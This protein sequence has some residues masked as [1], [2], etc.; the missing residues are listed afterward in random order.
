M[1]V[2][3]IR[4]NS[5]PGIVF[6]SGVRRF[7]ALLQNHRM[8]NVGM[9]LWRSSCPALVLKQRYSEPAGFWRSPRRRLHNYSRQDIPVLHYLHITEVL[10]DVQRELL[11]FQFMPIASWPGTGRHWK[12]HGS[13]LFATS[14]QV[15]I[16]SGEIPLTSSLSSLSSVSL[17]S[18]K[19]YSSPFSILVALQWTL[20][21]V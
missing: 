9:N 13:I 8:V 12:H 18:Q 16:D 1:E 14:L 3:K 5:Y 19:S 10:P 4:I 17:S 7:L 2:H 21:Y 6:R 20:Q 15:F 11:V